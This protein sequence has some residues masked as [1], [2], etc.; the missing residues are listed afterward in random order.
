[1][2]KILFVCLGNV[3]RSP[4][5]EGVFRALLERE[6]MGDEV[7]VDS[8]GTH[9]YHIDKSPDPRART[10][11]LARGIDIGRLRA[12]RIRM[13]DFEEFHQILV[14]DE[15]SYDALIFT[16]PKIYAHKIGYFLDYAPH[17]KSK[18]IPD[19]FYGDEMGFERMLD[20]IEDACQGLLQALLSRK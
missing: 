7:L 13:S 1:M 20:M 8:A 5:A 2:N 14:M 18:S 12:R 16:C 11:A 3:C 10:V 9:A 15:Q 19:P 17:L 6:G 4:T